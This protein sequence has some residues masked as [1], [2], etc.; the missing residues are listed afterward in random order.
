MEERD[1]LPE[2]SGTTADNTAQPAAPQPEK[3]TVT[4]T[5]TAPLRNENN[6]AAE[7]QQNADAQP[8]V[9]PQPSAVPPLQNNAPM[10]GQFAPPPDA[11]SAGSQY[12]SAQE[13]QFLRRLSRPQEDLFMIS[14]CMNPSALKDMT[15]ERISLPNSLRHSNSL[16]L[17]SFRK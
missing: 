3:E 15:A 1:N 12:N 4:H 14:S 13:G 17:R 2:Q 6:T 5:E 11:N 10:N 7:N 16:S 9:P 8:S